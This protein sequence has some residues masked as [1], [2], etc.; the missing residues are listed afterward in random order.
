V[1]T[2]RL[3]LEYDGT[4]FAGWQ[5]QRQGERTVQ[6][7]LAVALAEI[8]GAPVRVV[9]AGRTDA[10][11]HAEGQVAA[12]AFDT[13]L[14][15]ATLTRALNAKLPA[16]VAVVAAAHAR[17]G[18]DP[19]REAK[20]KLYRYAVWNGAAPSP[21]RRRRCHG[22]RERLDLAAM[23][24]AAS[25]LVGRHD[26]TSFR[27]AGS[28]VPS[29]VRTLARADVAGEAG[30][31]IRFELEGD[32]FLR[33]MVRNVVGTLLEV[34]LGRREAGSLPALLA[35]RDRSRAGPTAPARGLTLVRVD[36]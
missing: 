2:F 8:A 27:A 7:V 26:F 16:D 1:A 25:A 31:E 18:F 21:L 33:Q 35:A 34:G 17:D 29:A 5:S 24:S 6:D 14:D 12:V 15:L 22:V 11:V 23:A 10:G 32:G 13:R 3:T 4:D 28:A 30:G 36:Y 20:A 19:R 9:G